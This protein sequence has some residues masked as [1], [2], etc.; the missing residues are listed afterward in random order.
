MKELDA[1]WRDYAVRDSSG[2]Q[3]VFEHS[4]AHEGGNDVNPD[5]DIGFARRV[6][7]ELIAT[8]QVLD[9]DAEMRPLWQSF[10]DS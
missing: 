6:E 7:R 2:K 1:F 9:V 4:A 5:L 8:S 3:W 10:L